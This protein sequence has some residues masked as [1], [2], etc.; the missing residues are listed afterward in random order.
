MR[1]LHLDYPAAISQVSTKILDDLNQRDYFLID[2]PGKFISNINLKH[3][4]EKTK[5]DLTKHADAMRCPVV[6]GS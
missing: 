3:V 4:N 1:P 5:D 2:I 6:I